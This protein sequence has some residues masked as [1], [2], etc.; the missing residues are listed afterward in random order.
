MKDKKMLALVKEA[1]LSFRQRL[2]QCDFDSDD[3]IVFQELV[4]LRITEDIEAGKGELEVEVPKAY[5]SVRK[6]VTRLEKKV[7]AF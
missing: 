2:E 5:R 3:E 4:V 6:K 7:L 1:F